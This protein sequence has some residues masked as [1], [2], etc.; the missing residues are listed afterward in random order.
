M[1][2]TTILVVDDEPDILRLVEV[3]LAEGDW[4]VVCASD[5]EE[6]LALARRER[7]GAILL[8]SRMP[9]GGGEETLARLKDDPATRATPVI[10]MT[11]LARSSNSEVPPGYAG[12]I[13][14]PFDPL[15]LSD[16]IRS[17]LGT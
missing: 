17:I 14:K 5:G 3:V 8:D 7:P 6:A 13:P 11:A 4:R 15:T 2:P 10:L 12:V 9:R 16:T 1:E